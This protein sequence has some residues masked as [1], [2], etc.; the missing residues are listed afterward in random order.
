MFILSQLQRSYH[1]L[2]KAFYDYSDDFS[3]M[4]DRFD[5]FLKLTEEENK[6]S[7]WTPKIEHQREKFDIKELFP[8]KKDHISKAVITVTNNL[9]NNQFFQS[10]PRRF[11]VEYIKSLEVLLSI[12]SKRIFEYAGD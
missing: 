10:H 9:L 8:V 11:V 5:K 4:F 12:K 6:G 2:I 1:Y 7:I 3:D